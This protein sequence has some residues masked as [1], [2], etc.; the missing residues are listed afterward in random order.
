MDYNAAKGPHQGVYN[1][2]TV[3]LPCNIG[4]TAIYSSP[5]LGF[6][7]YNSKMTFAS[8]K[9]GRAHIFRVRSRF[10]AGHPQHGPASDASPFEFPATADTAGGTRLVVGQESMNTAVSFPLK[11]VM[12]WCAGIRIE[13]FGRRKPVPCQ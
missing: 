4:L 12:L 2:M 3:P 11:T 1:Q 7:S 5:G 6:N 9:D 13:R 8:V 10:P